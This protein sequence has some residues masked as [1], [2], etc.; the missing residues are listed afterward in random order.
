MACQDN[1][2][3]QKHYFPYGHVS[4]SALYCVCMRKFVNPKKA[5][6]EYLNRQVAVVLDVCYEVYSEELSQGNELL[7]KQEFGEKVVAKMKGE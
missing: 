7:S 1:T 2:L 6:V 3:L 4:R 5:I